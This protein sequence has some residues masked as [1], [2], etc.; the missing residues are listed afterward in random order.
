[1]PRNKIFRELE[2]IGDPKDHSKVL[3]FLHY[4]HFFLVD[5]YKKILSEY[6]LTSPQSNVL[7][8]VSH[9]HPGSMSLEEIKEWIMEPSS[10]VSRIVRRLVEKGLLEKVV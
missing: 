8:I 6:D 2:K 1:M 4:T 5:K 10:D 3:A 9:F 7:G